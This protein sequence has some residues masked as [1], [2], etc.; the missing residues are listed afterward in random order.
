MRIQDRWMRW[1][2]FAHTRQKRWPDVR[3]HLGCR[4]WRRLI[5][6]ENVRREWR[7]ELGSWMT[8]G[9]NTVIVIEEEALNGNWG[10][11]SVYLSKNV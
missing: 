8:I 7:H 10:A 11:R 6:Y 2:H 4:S 3:N 5:P 1:R 9:D